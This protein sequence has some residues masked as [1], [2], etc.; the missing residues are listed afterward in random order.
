MILPQHLFY[1]VRPEAI[2][3][4]ASWRLYVRIAVPG[5]SAVDVYLF[6]NMIID[7]NSPILDC[8]AAMS[9][10]WNFLYFRADIPYRRHIKCRWILLVV[11]RKLEGSIRC[12]KR[13][14]LQKS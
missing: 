7:M 8:W 13:V 5:H 6:Q 2:G 10:T 12:C 3:S 1:V 4:L 14:I 11:G 9:L